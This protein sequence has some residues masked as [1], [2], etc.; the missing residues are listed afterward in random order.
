MGDDAAPDTR[1]LGDSTLY[2]VAQVE[3]YAPPM[4]VVC[5]GGNLD[6]VYVTGSPDPA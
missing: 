5:S 1:S 4:E 3:D 2:L 6:H